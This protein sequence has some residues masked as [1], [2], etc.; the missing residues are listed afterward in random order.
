MCAH[1]FRVL[2]ELITS[3]E[4]TRSFLVIL[5]EDEE[6]DLKAKLLT[7]REG[8]SQILEVDARKAKAGRQED[9]QMIMDRIKARD[10]GVEEVNKPIIRALQEWLE[11]TAD[12]LLNESKENTNLL[13]GVV[14]LQS[15]CGL[16]G[17]HLPLRGA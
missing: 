17:R 10:G 2:Y 12:M 14:A 9:W 13:K 5:A 7:D 11:H 15:E 6:V 16:Q 3:I 4:K 1:D 8:F